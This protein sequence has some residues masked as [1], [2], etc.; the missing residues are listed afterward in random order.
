MD[1]LDA[2]I[3]AALQSDDS[4]PRETVREW[5]RTAQTVESLACLYRLTNEA[6]NRI[7][8]RLDPDETRFL[9]R[10]YLLLCIRMDPQHSIALPRYE[11]AAVL[12]SWFDHLASMAGARKTLQEVTTAVT[13]F[14]LSGDEQIRLAIETG[15]LEH[16][17]E[18]PS[19]RPFFSHWAQDKRLQGAWQRSLAWGEAHPNQMKR[20]REQL[21]SLEK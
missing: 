18:Q 14:F 1:E 21:L 17:L 7:Q 2:A 19:L 8:P 12:E 16:V 20:L 11:A 10:R 5:I 3:D 13:D 6:W 4:I 9:I 15:F